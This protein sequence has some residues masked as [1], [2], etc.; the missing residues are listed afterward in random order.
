MPGACSTGC[1][2][3]RRS[4]RRAARPRRARRRTRARRARARRRAGS[5]RRRRR[6]S[7]RSARA[8][9]T[10]RS[11]GRGAARAAYRSPARA[12]RDQVGEL[13][14]VVAHRDGG[15]LDPRAGAAARERAQQPQHVALEPVEA[16]VDPDALVGLGARAVD[17]DEDRLEPAARGPLRI[18]LRQHGQ[19][20]VDADR[21]A[22]RGGVVGHVEE[23]RVQQ[24][25][26]QALQ[27]QHGELRQRV[28]DAGV[29]VPGHERVGRVAIAHRAHP[30]AQVAVPDRLDLDETG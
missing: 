3:G 2:R 9:S 6:A 29:G 25:L 16:R 14:D 21:Y 19:V 4:A 17:R 20:G 12:Q 22:A 26:A 1:R 30:A 5:G 11:R 10:R 23:A 28:D 8:G 18:A 27:V 24:R 7:A 15:Q 13:V